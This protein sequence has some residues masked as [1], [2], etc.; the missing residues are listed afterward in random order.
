MIKGIDIGNSLTKD[1]LGYS[2]ESR[3]SSIGNI[4]GNKYNFEFQDS[5]Y[6]VGEGNFDT[7]YRK[8]EKDS[9]LKL[10]FSILAISGADRNLQIMLGLPLS[11]YKQDKQKLKELIKSNFI[12]E[13]KLNGLAKR[14]VVEDVEVFPEGIASL[15]NNYE[16]V[17]VD[18]GG[19]TTD[20]CMVTNINNRRNIEKPIS[21]SKGTLNLYSDFINL[22]NNRFSLD[23]QNRD[24]QRIIKNGLSIK[25]EKQNIGFAVNIFKEYLEDLIRDLNLQYSLS[26]NNIT[27]TGGGSLLLRNPILKRV[28]YASIE[29]NPIF[30]NAK[31]F[32]KE[33]C[34]LW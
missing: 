23:L 31:G 4:L 1:E 9:Y 3:I 33:G 30:S 12:L 34:R 25:G 16:G 11:Q 7:T 15:E 17:I 21:L 19:L 24:A 28:P 14:F 8:V 18:I 20:C 5:Y 22:I 32:Y 6:V 2:F 10:L 26:T 29:E 27:F 13:G